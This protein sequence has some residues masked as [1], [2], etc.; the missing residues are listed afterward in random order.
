MS[1]LPSLQDIKDGWQ[2]LLHN[3]G[4]AKSFPQMGRYTFEEKMEYWAF[5][6][7]AVVMGATGFM[8]WNPI[9]ATQYLPGEFVPAAKAAHGGEAVLAVLAIIIWHMY[10]VHI[11]RFNKAMFDGKMTEEDMLHEHPL[12]LADIKAGIADRRPDAATIRKRQMIYYPIAAILTVGML[13]GIFG[14]INA[15]ETA[16][17]TVVPVSETIPQNT[18]STP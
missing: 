4:F 15:E 10:G 17:T 18:G 2:A 13:A 8:M 7:G 11:K 9:T 5:V 6:W 14:F 12:E 3:L 16:I 1:M